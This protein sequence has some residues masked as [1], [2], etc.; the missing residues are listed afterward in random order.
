MSGEPRA[1]QVVAEVRD[2]LCGSGRWD[3]PD[4]QHP[5]DGLIEAIRGAGAERPLFAAAVALLIADPDLRVRTG[6]VACLR[7]I[8]GDIPLRRVAEVV[9]G[10][11][12]LFRGVRPAWRLESSDLEQVA[13]VS[14]A[15]RARAGDPVVLPWLEGLAGSRAWGW[16]LLEDLARLDPDW[17]VE[18]AGL[19]EHDNLAVIAALPADRRAELIA[20][21]APWPPERPTA[22]SR[23]FWGRLPAAESARLRALMWP[24]AA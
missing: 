3:G 17:L 10:S 12:E 24:E 22:L 7:E 16:Y 23:A 8:G 4:T 19:V 5:H 20:R 15:A 1:V 14:A 6:A 21:R 13:A 9:A 11:P 18:N 2:H